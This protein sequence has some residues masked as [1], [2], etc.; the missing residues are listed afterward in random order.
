MSN[1]INILKSEV[2][3]LKSGCCQPTSNFYLFTSFMLFILCLVS[4]YATAQQERKPIRDGNELYQKHKYD[5]AEKK[6][7]EA[8]SV[9]PN[10]AEGIYNKANVQYQKKDYENAAKQYETAA[11]L[12]GEPMVK[13]K[14][15]HNMGNSLLEAKKY[16][17]SVEAYKNALRL[18][19]K[20]VDTKYNLAYALQKLKQQQQNQ[21]QNKDENKENKDEKQNQD[22][23]NRQQQNQQEKKQQEQQQQNEQQQQQAEKDD[24][25]K[26]EPRQAQISKAD[27]EKLLDALKNEEQ[28][29]QLKLQKHKGQSTTGKVEKD[30]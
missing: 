7:D 14:A 21:Q 6:Y 27:A 4:L 3:C 19:P 9:K 30:W 5:E 25:K 22:K 29:V 26:E 24:N 28:K 8:L 2:R 13:A 18:N 10:L 20:D 12:S 15:Y 16:K 23:Q 1:S 11:T 17:E